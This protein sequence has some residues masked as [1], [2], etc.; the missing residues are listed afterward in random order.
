MSHLSVRLGSA[1][2]STEL[3]TYISVITG[4]ITV[5]C[6]SSSCYSDANNEFSFDRKCS[7]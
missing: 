7:C 1:V 3:E 6:R 5:K 4:F 2:S